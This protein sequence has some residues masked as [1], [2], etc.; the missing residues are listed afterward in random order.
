MKVALGF[1]VHSGWAAYVVAE[2]F[3]RLP[4]VVERGRIE[5]ADAPDTKQPYHA[6]EGLP[7]K[8]AQAL[9][10]RFRAEAGRRADGAIG[11]VVNSLRRRGDEVLGCGLLLGSGRPSTS[12]EATLASHA[13]IHTADGNHFR[14]AIT[15]ACGRHG[16]AVVGIRER[17][18]MEHASRALRAS[19]PELLQRLK[20]VGRALGPPFRQNE[21]YAA[22]AAWSVLAA[23]KR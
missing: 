18:L 9:L 17:E 10:G 14:D 21:K 19:P 2:A 13:L 20:D 16:L 11:D 12:L 3:S 15:D 1:S 8:E 6:A 4:G 7:L 5:M 23:V 22:L